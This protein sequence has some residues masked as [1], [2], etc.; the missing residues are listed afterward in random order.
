MLLDFQTSFDLTV[1]NQE[2]T[3]IILVDYS[4]SDLLDAEPITKALNIINTDIYLL[5]TI[6]FE[7]ECTLAI[8]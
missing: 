4:E 5:F 8:D 1:S 7:H 6:I 3:I 2:G